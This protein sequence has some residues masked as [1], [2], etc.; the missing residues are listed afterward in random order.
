MASNTG[1]VHYKRRINVTHL[2]FGLFLIYM[3][4][5]V[6]KYVSQDEIKICEVTEGALL[7]DQTY[8]GLIIRSEKFIETNK[9][10]YLKCYAVDG[11]RIQ[12][13]RVVFALGRS[14]D[15][16]VPETADEQIYTDKQYYTLR[17]YLNHFSTSYNGQNFSNVYT[18][19]AQ[20]DTAIMGF[21]QKGLT[22]SEEN[23][24]VTLY[25]APESGI[26]QFTIDDFYDITEEE[27]TRE[28]LEKLSFSQ[29]RTV[30]GEYLKKGTQVCRIIYE[31]QWS[32]IIP[33]TEA[34]VEYFQNRSTA[35][36]MLNTIGQ[37]TKAR[38]KVYQDAD[39]EY[40]AKLTFDNYLSSYTADRFISIQLIKDK[41]EGLKVPASSLV[42]KMLYA[43]PLSY[44]IKDEES[45]GISFYVQD[46][47]DIQLKELGIIYSD[48][49]NFYIS[50]SE[51]SS[52]DRIWPADANGKVDQQGEV[53]EINSENRKKLYGVYN[54]NKGYVVFERVRIID[55]NESYCIIEPGESKG[56]QVFDRIVLN[57]ALVREDDL[58]Y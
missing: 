44:G 20:L 11:E 43:V 37:S 25:Q 19:K 42:S 17:K 12:K 47:D 39:G 6:A 34:D 14:D 55:Q 18:L 29:T 5:I 13:G 22:V 21:A 49:T 1:N 58:L 54:V 52:G 3:I 27:I 45:K 7:Q 23:P 51:L 32:V 41:K 38:I 30:G 53:Y 33:I 36:V 24:D 28:N 56:L 2:I 35:Q 8:S 40:L 4:V 31:E 48:E 10:G 26:I 15:D 57:A 16:L 46:K 50:D 9:D